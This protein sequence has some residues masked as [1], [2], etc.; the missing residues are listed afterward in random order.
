MS[1]IDPAFPKAFR[2]SEEFQAF[3]A[4]TESYLTTVDSLR[5]RSRLNRQTPKR[6]QK[7][8]E[9]L[10]YNISTEAWLQA[11]E[12]TGSMQDNML[13][14]LGYLCAELDNFINDIDSDEY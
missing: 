8:L 12:M 4:F 7:F 9:Q 11:K 10:S 3:R 1:Y 14:Q 6:Q 13:M 2:M 5:L